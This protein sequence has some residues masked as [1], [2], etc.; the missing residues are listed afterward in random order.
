MRILQALLLA[1]A[2]LCAGPLA[3]EDQTRI[4]LDFD[5]IELRQAIQFIL[6]D[7]RDIKFVTGEDL[8]EKVTVK[9]VNVEWRQALLSLLKVH[10]YTLAEENSVL[11]VVKLGESDPAS[12][13][14]IP[15]LVHL[16]HAEPE[17]VR[18]LLEPMLSADG[19]VLL[20]GSGDN[21]QRILAVIDGPEVLALVRDLLPTLDQPPT[22]FTGTIVARD[23][24]TIDIDLE[25]FPLSGIPGLL[26][27]QLGLNVFVNGALAGDANIHVNGVHW[28]QA[29]ALVLGEAGYVF[30][31][32]DGVVIISGG[33]SAT[34]EM[35]TQ[36]F[37]LRYVD[38]WDLLPYI[39]PLLSDG[40]SIAVY[41]PSQR[42]G[43]AFGGGITQDVRM[44]AVGR[45][46][47]SRGRLLSV[48][49]RPEIVAMVAERVRGIDQMPKQ[50]QVDVKIVQID[51]DSGSRTGIDWSTVLSLTGAS[52][53]TSFPFP[54][55]N[56]GGEFF[57]PV[58]EPTG[59]TFGSLAAD[60]LTA[61]LRMIE[62]D[63]ESEIISEPNIT[64]L[65][66]IEA[67]ILIGQKFPLT[68]ETI[69]PQTAVR[70]VTLD[71][72]EDSGIQLLVVPTITEGNRVH[73]LIHPAV[74][75]IVE[76]IEDRFPVINTREA[77]TQLLLR[78]GDTAVIGGLIERTTS[79]KQRRIP[80]LGK[81][82]FLGWFFS[83]TEEVR[84]T[85]ELVIFVTPRIVI[86]PSELERSL[87]VGE[88]RRE[89]LSRLRDLFDRLL[90]P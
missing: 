46:S 41:S 69:D 19:K 88:E 82:P 73:M 60:Q 34:G 35:V 89:H 1:G 42:A 45:P 7:R 48:T 47:K 24:G 59:F 51:R 72:Y 61:V 58:V 54:T 16:R 9:L 20:L 78:S 17:A 2:C 65:D 80:L 56:A 10:G 28:E 43:F 49:D 75:S 40:S 18:Q 33:E 70:T 12:R 29:L 3:A 37:K 39:E 11:R 63:E 55:K 36:E 90:T 53:D 74:S 25:D 23:D 6:R 76:L 32:E 62:E 86:D 52:R 68:K 71:R 67:S 64:A 4:T 87:I 30:R 21:G 57:G 38:G 13:Q 8:A 79:M 14:R 50:V 22:H 84:S 15:L 27:E 5:E 26:E 83:Y 81:I 85:S 77:D 66:N 31:Q 44:N